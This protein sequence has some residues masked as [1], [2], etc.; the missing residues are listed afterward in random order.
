MPAWRNGH[1]GSVKLLTRLAWSKP[2]E[3]VTRFE[4]VRRTFFINH[5]SDGDVERCEALGWSCVLLFAL[6]GSERLAALIAGF[7]MMSGQVPR[8][9]GVKPSAG[10][11]LG[12][13]M[14]V[15]VPP[16]VFL[17]K[18]LKQERWSMH[19]RL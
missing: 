6:T 5:N 17:H 4:R 14:D 12:D 11:S 1:R 10:V 3:R 15:P 18:Q 9:G 8:D 16:L 13:F 2:Q 7:T 19:K